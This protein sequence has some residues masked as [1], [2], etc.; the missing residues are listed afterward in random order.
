MPGDDFGLPVPPTRPDTQPKESH[1]RASTPQ[2][3]T[4]DGSSERKASNDSFGSQWTV[5][6]APVSGP[7]RSLPIQSFHWR[8]RTEF[9]ASKARGIQQKRP[10]C[11]QG[12]LMPQL[13]P[14]VQRLYG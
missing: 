12:E 7:Y 9:K 13:F 4:R 3:A 11:H 6:I 5:N 2:T 10:Y 8:T 14:I 1:S